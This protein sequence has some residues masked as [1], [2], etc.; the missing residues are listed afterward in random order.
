MLSSLPPPSPIPFSPFLSLRILASPA[1]R[2]SPC[3][4]CRSPAPRRPPS[5]PSRRRDLHPC[6][7]LQ[8]EA[9]AQPGCPYGYPHLPDE[10]EGAR[11]HPEASSL[12][13]GACTPPH[14]GLGSGQGLGE[15]RYRCRW[16]PASSPVSGLS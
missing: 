8:A 14:T 13:P 10:E 7:D 15:G 3:S 9:S 5:G 11:A 4:L 16:G 2:S 6:S 12:S 1:P